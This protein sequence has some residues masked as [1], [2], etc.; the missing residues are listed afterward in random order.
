MMRLDFGKFRNITA[1]TTTVVR[2]GPGVLVSIV[3]NETNA[4]TITIYDNT[5]ASGTIVGTIAAA[6]AAGTTF[7]YLCQV[8]NGITVVTAGADDITVVYGI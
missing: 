2:T 1:A 8:S 6:T 4:G 5:A 7:G 3:L